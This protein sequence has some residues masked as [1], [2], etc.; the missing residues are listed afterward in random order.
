MCS[1][2][3]ANEMRAQ[4]E[5]ATETEFNCA[6]KINRGLSLYSFNMTEHRSTANVLQ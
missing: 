1:F 4:G 6:V 2:Q 3:I 5:V